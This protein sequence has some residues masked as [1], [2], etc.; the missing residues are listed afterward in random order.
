MRGWN[1]DTGSPTMGST[2]LAEELQTSASDLRLSNNKNV[3]NRL[4]RPNVFVLIRR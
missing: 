4:F 2:S 3:V 1:P